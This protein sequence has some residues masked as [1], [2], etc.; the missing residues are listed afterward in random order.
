MLKLSFLPAANL[1]RGRGA[2]PALPRD[3]NVGG[4][5]PVLGKSRVAVPAAPPR[6]NGDAYL[7]TEP[8]NGAP[9]VDEDGSDS[10]AAGH[11][12]A[13]A[14]NGVAG[15]DGNGERPADGDDASARGERMTRDEASTR[16]SAA[17]R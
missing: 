15:A 1:D 4:R 9:D 3:Q 8:I 11:N 14:G 10:A 2:E 17:F 5:R 6:S 16:L 13:A 12:S 7:M